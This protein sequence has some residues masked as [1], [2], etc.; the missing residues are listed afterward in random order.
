MSQ[1]FEGTVIFLNRYLVDVIP[2]TGTRSSCA[3]SLR[4]RRGG[5]ELLK[6]VSLSLRRKDLLPVFI[7]VL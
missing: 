6:I 1:R 5:S 7:L 4:V 3:G 2:L